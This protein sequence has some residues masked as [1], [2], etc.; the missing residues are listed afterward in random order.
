MC[1]SERHLVPLAAVGRHAADRSIRSDRGE[2]KPVSQNEGIERLA[3]ITSRYTTAS[4]S[5]DMHCEDIIHP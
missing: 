2:N 4:M 1:R 3:A 5:S